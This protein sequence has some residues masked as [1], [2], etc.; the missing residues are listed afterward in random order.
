MR[1][2]T[3]SKDNRGDEVLA[4]GALGEWAEV[5]EAGLWRS[6]N[7]EVLSLYHTSL[8][9]GCPEVSGDALCPGMPFCWGSALPRAKT[10]GAS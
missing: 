5:E 4:E 3:P 7:Y 6:R 9:P 1:T 10:T 2:L 8:T